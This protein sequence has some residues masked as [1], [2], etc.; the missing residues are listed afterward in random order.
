MNTTIRIKDK[1]LVVWHGSPYDHNKFDMSKIG[2]G[3]GNLSYGFGHYFASNKKIAEYYRETIGSLQVNTQEEI[4]KA[5]GNSRYFTTK[6]R[7]EIYRS[8]IGDEPIDVVARILGYR[9]ASL[10]DVNEIE[11][12]KVISKVRKAAKGKLYK[13]ELNA[14]EKK[15]LQWDK[16]LPLKFKKAIVNGLIDRNIEYRST[17]RGITAKRS[18]DITIDIDFDNGSATYQGLSSFFMGDDK[19]ASQYLLSVGI[20]GIKYLDGVSRNSDEGTFN[21]VIFDD[22]DISIAEKFDFVGIIDD[23]QSESSESSS[24]PRL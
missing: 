16:P 5:F 13:V 10:R 22:N 12:T 7:A 21:Y 8:A 11:L 14:D 2:T 18:D 1:K 3:E 23:E 24:R 17:P 19:E 15:Y 4:E 20:R 6:E 9:Q